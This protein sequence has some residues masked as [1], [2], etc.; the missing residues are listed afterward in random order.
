M[1]RGVRRKPRTAGARTGSRWI[2]ALLVGMALAA[3]APAVVGQERPGSPDRAR[4]EERV[5]ERMAQIIRE[6]LALN[7]EEARALEE[8]VRETQERRR[9]LERR[10]RDVRSSLQAFEGG[11]RADDEDARVLLERMSDLR[12]EEAQLFAEEQDALMEVLSPSQVLLLHKL[13]AQMMDRIREL[14]NP[15]GRRPPRGGPGG[16][17]GESFGGLLR[18]R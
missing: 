9:E 18:E 7:E 10:E 4:L 6:R 5:R 14:R 3:S 13:R 17:A 11:E 1:R 8:V 12:L 16:P 2:Q 15:G